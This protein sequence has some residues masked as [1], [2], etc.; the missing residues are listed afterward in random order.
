MSKRTRTVRTRW[1]LAVPVI[2]LAAIVAGVVALEA[3]HPQADPGR[4]VVDGVAPL[5]MDETR[6]CTRGD[7][8][9]IAEEIRA[10]LEPGQRVTSSQVFACPM[11]FDTQQVT[12]TGE[13]VGELLP[14]RGGTWAQVNDDV[15]AL[16]V[17]PVVG[18][19]E[20]AGFNTGMSV[21]LPDG[22]HERIERPG[23]AGWRGD[24]VQVTGVVL[25][26]DPEDGGGITLRAE[27]LEVLAAPA[28]APAPLHVV[29][30]IAAV[31]LAVLA[32]ASVWLARR[33]RR[34]TG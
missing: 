30:A 14:R 10:A 1:L 31:A 32:I 27:G 11:A 5:A 16:E 28:E 18:H 24:V 6:R 7:D 15:Y 22:L 33:S 13:V 34:S 29:Q 26:V 3:I 12:Y 25:R 2:G 8:G 19:R 4:F 21:W 9:T 17:G 23:R 20:H